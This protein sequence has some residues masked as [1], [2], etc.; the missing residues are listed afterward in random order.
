MTRCS[1][2]LA[3]V[4]AL[5]LALTGCATLGGPPP[6]TAEQVV[7]MAKAGEPADA[8]IKRLRETYTVIPLSASDMV[9]LNKEGVPTEVLDYL[10]FAQLNEIRR[11][12]QL[13]SMMYP[14][15]GYGPYPCGWRYRFAPGPAFGPWPWG[16]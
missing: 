10:Q 3:L 2:T 12:E 4:A 9:R 11:R 13:S 8:I 1:L 15:A 5:A 16:C 7:A 6:L 14:Y